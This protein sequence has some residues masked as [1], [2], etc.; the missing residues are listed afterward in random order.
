M[1]LTVQ[2]WLESSGESRKQTFDPFPPDGDIPMG[3]VKYSAEE[4]TFKI[5]MGAAYRG[6]YDM[7]ADRILS[8]SGLLDFL[9]Q[10]HQYEWCTGQHMKDFLDCVTCW[11][12]RDHGKFPQAFFDVTGGMNSGLDAP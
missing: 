7:A 3:L 12:Y 4:D 8:G 9:F 2:Q 11:V 10:I 6:T 5:Q 1:Q